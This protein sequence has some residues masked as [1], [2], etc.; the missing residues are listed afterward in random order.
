MKIS[1]IK[2]YNIF[3][4]KILNGRSSIYQFP[5]FVTVEESIEKQDEERTNFLLQKF[6]SQLN[7][8]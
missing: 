2:S 1:M 6:N 5:N 4:L 8:V 7:I 3:Q